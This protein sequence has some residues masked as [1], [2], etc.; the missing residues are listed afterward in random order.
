VLTTGDNAYPDGTAT[1]YSDRY[2]PT[3]GRHKAITKPV[4]G[5]HDYHTSGAAGYFGYFGTAAGDPAKGYYAYDMG[6]WRLYALNSNIAVSASSAQVA[7]LKADLAANPRACVMAYWHHPRFSAG[8]YGDSTA[9][10]PL[11]QAL[12]DA[13]AEIVLN[14]HDHNYQRYVP[15]RPDGTIDEAGGIR[16]FV[17]GMG[18]TGHYALQPRTDGRRA[19]ADDTAFGVLALTLKPAGYDWRF[20]PEAGRTFSDSGSGSCH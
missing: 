19:A 15:M 12:Q 17:L 11:W 3:W 8:N 13:G 2:A 14:G 6:G 20:V 1:D 9:Y 10:E 18:G 4:P 5:N 7:W 16:E